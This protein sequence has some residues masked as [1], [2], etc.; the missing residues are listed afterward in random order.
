M[1]ESA[2]TPT[3]RFDTVPDVGATELLKATTL[4]LSEQGPI[5]RQLPGFRSRE[6][7]QGLAASIGQA[8][9]SRT[10]LVAEAGTGTGKTFAYLV[11]LLLSGRRALVSTGTRHLQDQLHARDL[12]AVRAALGSGVR[13]AVLKGRANYVCHHHL[14]RLLRAS[15]AR[16]TGSRRS[17][18]PVIGPNATPWPKT[19]RSGYKPPPRAK[20]VWV[21]SVLR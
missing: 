11:P 3:T 4:A 8:L 13:C 16:S 20:I 14:A 15:C 19:I 2:A 10:A 12:P 6:G 17:R 5:A 9:A 21:R 7:Q 18:R 1:P